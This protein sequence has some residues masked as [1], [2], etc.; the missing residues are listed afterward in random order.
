MKPL[1]GCREITVSDAVELRD[2]ELGWMG[3]PQHRHQRDCGGL[4]KNE[5][6]DPPGTA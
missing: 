2:T 4:D 3:L 5:D 6:A 1:A